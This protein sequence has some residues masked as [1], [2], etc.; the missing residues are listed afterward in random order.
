ML[1]G[2]VNC[3]WCDLLDKPLVGVL[4]SSNESLSGQRSESALMLIHSLGLIR[5]YKDQLKL[6]DACIS[7][8][9]VIH[10]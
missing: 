6:A 5:I 4:N 2:H 7:L 1:I 9:S 3:R 8:V 10:I